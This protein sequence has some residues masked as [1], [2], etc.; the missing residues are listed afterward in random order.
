[1]IPRSPESR[2]PSPDPRQI[3]IVRL[4]SLGDIVHGL[5]VA[6]ALRERWPAAR[7]DWLVDRRNV[8]ILRLVP[9]LDHVL[10][11]ETPTARGWLDVLREIR[12][13]RYDAAIDLQGLLKS[14]LLAR[15]SGARRVIGF[16]STHLR[17][18]TA[19]PFY[20]E[21]VDPG[22][23]THVMHKNAALARALGV[24][25]LPLRFPLTT[26]ASPALAVVRHDLGVAP[27]SGGAG[28]HPRDR[29]ALINPGAAWLN[30]RWL[31]DRFGKVAAFVRERFGLSSIVLWGPGEEARAREVADASGGAARLAPATTIA[32]LVELS[33]A[34]SLM[35]SGDTGPL[36]IAAA[37]GTPIVSLFGPT[38]PQRNGP[39]A[40]GDEVLSR[41][42]QCE[43]RYQRRCR[44]AAWCLAD[45]TV[46]EVTAAIE[47]RMALR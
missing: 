10:V 2:V 33:R 4:G 32:D 22:P 27:D 45:I 25:D 34:A 42:G 14:A 5:P 31:P 47:R 9:V 13:V 26:G 30:K 23:V 17:E 6:A 15:L 29:F 40:G 28:P 36:H 46:A 37:V 18:R 3:L 19:A 1:V 24:T 8:E 38:D 35:I 11:L 39:W 7:L 43:C 16:A 12:P 21:R 20:S 44:R 41:W